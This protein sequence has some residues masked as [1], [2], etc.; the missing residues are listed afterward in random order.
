[1]LEIVRPGR[2]ETSNPNAQ[3]RDFEQDR[4]IADGDMVIMTLRHGPVPPGRRMFE[5]SPEEAIELARPYGLQPVLGRR[6]VSIQAIN[7][8]AGV[9]WSTVA[10]VKSA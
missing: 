9:S 5:V 3:S 7:R 6:S 8:P 1:M 2:C 4:Q 10:M